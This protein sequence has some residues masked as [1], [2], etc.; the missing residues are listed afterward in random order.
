MSLLS[1]RVPHKWHREFLTTIL[2]G[3]DFCLW[4]DGELTGAGSGHFSCWL[5]L[6]QQQQQPKR[7]REKTITSGCC[8]H[9]RKTQHLGRMIACDVYTRMY[10][11]ALPSHLQHFS[12]IKEPLPY[13][14]KGCEHQHPSWYCATSS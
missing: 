1:S 13:Q 6:D 2:L 3:S 10:G 8:F 5:I 11:A 12:F 7:N 14:K 9:K 4:Q